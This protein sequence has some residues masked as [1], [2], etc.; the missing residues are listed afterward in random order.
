M[1]RSRQE[2]VDLACPS[3]G[4]HFRA[5][6]WLVVDRAE[7]PDLVQRLI[8]GQLDDARC[9][10]CGAEGAINH[11]LLLHDPARMQVYCALPLSVQGQAAARDMVGELLQALV[12]ALPLAERLPYLR[13]VEIVVELDGLRAILVEQTLADDAAAEDRLLA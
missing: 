3:C 9:P 1:S 6:V 8:A 4:R 5:A 13:E 7:R 11:P 10:H 2:P 12:A